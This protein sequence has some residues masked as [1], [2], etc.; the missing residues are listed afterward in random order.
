MCDENETKN[1]S[2]DGHYKQIYF[3]KVSAKGNDCKKKR[4]TTLSLKI[5]ID[6]L[7][8]KIWILY[9]LKVLFNCLE[10]GWV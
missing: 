5:W 2:N 9:S 3:R 6:S 7:S 8:L 10:V 4:E 1:K